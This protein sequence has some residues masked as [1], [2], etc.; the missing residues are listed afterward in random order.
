[1]QIAASVDVGS[2]RTFSALQYRRVKPSGALSLTAD[3]VEKQR[4]AA[5]N[6]LAFEAR[7]RLSL[8]RHP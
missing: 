6:F 2:I 1:M 4:V 3:S 5:Q 8:W 7:E